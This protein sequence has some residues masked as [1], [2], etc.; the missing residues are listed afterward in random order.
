MEGRGKDDGRV[1]KD[2]GRAGK[3]GGRGGRARKGTREGRG[4]IRES[5][6]DFCGIILK[7]LFINSLW[8]VNWI[9]EEK[10]I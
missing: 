6:A 2:G 5:G 10:R 9:W 8:V 7:E 3:D 1:G 4:R